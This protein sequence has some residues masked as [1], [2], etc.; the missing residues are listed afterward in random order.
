MARSRTTWTKGASGNPKG[1]PKGTSKLT[2][3]REKLA[4][5]ADQLIAKVVEQALEG[6]T[7][8]L[9]LCLERI[10]PALRPKEAATDL[11][12]LVVDGSLADQARSIL[13]QL[14]AGEIATGDAAALLRGIAAQI[15][16]QEFEEL[17]RRIAA[18]EKRKGE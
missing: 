15:Q 18:L 14:K 12:G 16:I 1:R 3:Y 9:R 8:A 10:V 7:T 2:E 17:E 5:H 4:A 6:D 11:P 13:E